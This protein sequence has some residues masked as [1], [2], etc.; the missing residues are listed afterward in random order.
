MQTMRTIHIIIVS[1]L[2]TAFTN[3]IVFAQSNP[4]YAVKT[5]V[6]DAGHGGHD[7]GACGKISKEKNITLSLALKVGGLISTN[8]PDV[9]V[10]YTR[11]TD[12]FIEL[13]NRANI[14]NKAK[15]D[16]FISIH[17]NANPNPDANGTE[18]YT[19]GVAK[20]EANLKVAKMEN[21]VI[22]LESDASQYQGM[23]ANDN[24][25]IILHN[26]Q[27]GAFCDN[28]LAFAGMIQR[29]FREE[30]GRKDRS[31]QQAGFLVLWKTAMPS[32]LIETGFIS[33]TEEEI[34]LNNSDNQAELA[35][36]I[37]RAFVEYKNYIEKRSNGNVSIPDTPSQTTTKTTNTTNAQAKP[38]TTKPAIATNTTSSQK[39]TS[40]TTSQQNTLGITYSIQIGA[41]KEKNACT[42]SNFKGLNGVF[43]IEEDGLYKY[44]YGKTST[45]KEIS[46]L[47]QEVKEKYPS[48]YIIA[49]DKDNKKLQVAEARKK[50]N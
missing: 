28:S 13:Y 23:S 2:L 8:C 10:I 42:P 20:N 9:K 24:E 11:K 36:A 1:I 4:S 18:T 27:Q 40:Q 49:R 48:A 3:A 14:A 30:V 26:L 46:A 50:T 34:W 17:V 41:G 22:S 32:V 16:L 29:Q 5:V 21:A 31:V 45:Y 37:Y 7:P 25:A 43:I 44:Y 12:E 15:A 6:I 47:M 38:S 33:N 19:M 35:Y 39:Q